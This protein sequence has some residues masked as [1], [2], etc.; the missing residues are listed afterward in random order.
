[1]NKF[2]SICTD[3]HTQ[4]KKFLHNIY[5]DRQIN[6]SSVKSSEQP[7]EDEKIFQ[8]REV[9]FRFAGTGFRTPEQTVL[10]V[11]IPER[12]LP[13]GYTAI[14]HKTAY[15]DYLLRL[16]AVPVNSLTDGL[17]NEQKD[18]R[19]KAAFSLQT[20]GAVVQGRNGCIYVEEKKLFGC[21]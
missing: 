19:E 13:G 8:Y 11:F 2:K 3:I 1:M 16:L 17:Q 5:T 15:E 4:N 7:I 20:P 9:T 14:S 6:R 21:G 18:A 10:F 12:L